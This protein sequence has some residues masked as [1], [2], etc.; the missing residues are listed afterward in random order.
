[1]GL[2]PTSATFT[3]SHWSRTCHPLSFSRLYSCFLLLEC[4]FLLSTWQTP[5]CSL[6]LTTPVISSSRCSMAF[7]PQQSKALL[8]LLYAL[9]GPC[10]HSSNELG[11]MCLSSCKTLEGM[12]PDYFP[13]YPQHHVQYWH[14]ESTQ[15]FVERTTLMTFNKLP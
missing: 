13:L 5:A 7:P 2:L 3:A 1:M 14:L 4:P 15:M 10:S 12:L 8:P 9:R 11:D 6:L